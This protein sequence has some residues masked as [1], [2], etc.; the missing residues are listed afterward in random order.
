MGMMYGGGDIKKP[1][2]M[3]EITDPVETAGME[4][5]E[6]VKVVITGV[7]TAMSGPRDDIDYNPRGSK[8][9]KRPGCVEMQI[10]KIELMETDPNE[11]SESE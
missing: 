9:V 5:G 2:A 7:I 11:N 6:P 10:K 1:T 3:I 4:L 8:T